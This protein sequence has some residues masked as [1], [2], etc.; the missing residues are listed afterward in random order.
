MIFM[1]TKSFNK[2]F[3]QTKQDSELK[4]GTQLVEYIMH[5]CTEAF[6]NNA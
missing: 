3:G 6:C 5:V 2:D 1:N 4:F